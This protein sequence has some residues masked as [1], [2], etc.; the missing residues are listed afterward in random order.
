[1]SEGVIDG[2]EF[3]QIHKQNRQNMALSF[4]QLKIVPQAIIEQSPVWQARERIVGGLISQSV[5]LLPLL[6]DIRHDGREV[7]DATGLI[8]NRGHRELIPKGSAALMV[9]FEGY[10]QGR[11]AAY[12]S[13]HLFQVFRVSPRAVQ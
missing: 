9:A 7:T 11:S 13:F 12:G 8:T 6:G 2:F 3:V 1:M 4:C 5:L 10:F